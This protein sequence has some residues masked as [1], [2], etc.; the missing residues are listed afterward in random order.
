[1]LVVRYNHRIKTY[2]RDV[3][4]VKKASSE[5]NR[6]STHFNRAVESFWPDESAHMKALLLETPHCVD[7][8]TLKS[9]SKYETVISFRSLVLGAVCVWQECWNVLQVCK[10][11]THR[12][13]PYIGQLTESL[14]NK[15][16]ELIRII[17][18]RRYK[19]LALCVFSL[20]SAY[21][22]LQAKRLST[23]IRNPGQL[24]LLNS[25][26]CADPFTQSK[27]VTELRE[28][29]IQLYANFRLH[30]RDNIED[31]LL[32]LENYFQP[33]MKEMLGKKTWLIC[34]QG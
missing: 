17:E 24:A 11:K 13:E 3:N 25:L 5:T 27:T 23:F 28:I 14:G 6:V 34:E 2:M 9:A 26:C 20:Q 12:P 7:S 1:M 22:Y 21:L 10:R 33:K 32:H 29:N 19:Q 18:K 15:K 4:A 31:F 16:T 30:H 8:P